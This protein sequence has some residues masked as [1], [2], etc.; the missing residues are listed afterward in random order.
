MWGVCPKWEDSADLKDTVFLS[1]C[2]DGC[3][4]GKVRTRE[5]T[6]D[7]S[8]LSFCLEGCNLRM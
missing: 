7:T 1:L 2:V 4:L 3:N 8:R 6:E 5:D